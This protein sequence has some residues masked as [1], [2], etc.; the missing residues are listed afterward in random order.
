M[1]NELQL[2]TGA[3]RTTFIG[4]KVI[5]ESAQQAGENDGAILRRADDLKQWAIPTAPRSHYKSLTHIGGIDL[6]RSF[7]K[8]AH[9]N[10][11]GA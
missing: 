5:R 11:N 6:W 1:S 3:Y 8:V 9:R 4:T 10:I 7:L 2:Q